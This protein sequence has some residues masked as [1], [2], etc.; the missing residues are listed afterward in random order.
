MSLP[1]GIRHTKTVSL[2]HY[3]ESNAKLGQGMLN[4]SLWRETLI[5]IIHQLG[6]KENWQDIQEGPG[7]FKNNIMAGAL[8]LRLTT[9]EIGGHI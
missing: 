3:Q 7:G 2:S 4:T 9:M 8:E 5:S 6:E 1:D